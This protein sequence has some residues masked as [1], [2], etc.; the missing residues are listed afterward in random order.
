LALV[1]VVV[2]ATGTLASGDSA[3][4]SAVEGIRAAPPVYTTPTGPLLPDAQLDTIAH[5]E[6]SL[7]QENSPSDIHAV[8]TS[9]RS[10]VEVD[11][12][13]VLPEAPDAG[14]AALDASTV[15]LVTMHGDF[16]LRDAKVPDGRQAPSGNILTL[17]LDAHT[18]QLE[19]RAISD[20][21][22]SGVARL[23]TGRPLEE[24]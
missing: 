13:N 2:G 9:L 11:S 3:T 16:T 7:A 1:V 8:D 22:A 6:A 21:Q 18:G 17:I 5:R 10:A 4:P 14:D 23:G 24:G 20:E 15:V 19:G 12:H